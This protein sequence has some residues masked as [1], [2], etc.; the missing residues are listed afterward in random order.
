MLALAT[1]IAPFI[2]MDGYVLRT[3]I[4][5]RMLRLSKLGRY[6]KALKNIGSAIARRKEELFISLGAAILLLIVS[7]SILYV[8]EGT[9]QSEHFGSIPRAMWWAVATLTT[10]GYGMST[11]LPLLAVSLPL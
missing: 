6:S 9:D 1:S 11:R 4:L 5:L 10:V 7:S 3:M 2:P 8:V